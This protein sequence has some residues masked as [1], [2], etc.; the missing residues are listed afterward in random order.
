VWD[1]LKFRAVS[2]GISASRY[3]GGHTYGYE[4]V[5]TINCTPSTGFRRLYTILIRISSYS[6]PEL[7][8]PCAEGPGVCGSGVEA[9]VLIRSDSWSGISGHT[10]S[11]ALAA[12]LFGH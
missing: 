4:S 11:V 3:G 5:G 2:Q 6:G 9:G 8:V 7:W 12:I 1:P 10:V